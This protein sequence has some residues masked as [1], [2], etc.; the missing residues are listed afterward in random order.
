MDLST[1]QEQQIFDE[2]VGFSAKLRQ[3]DITLYNINPIGVSEPLGLADYY[4]NFLNGV[5]KPYQAQFG[6]LGLQVLAT[7]SG[8]LVFEGN[9]DVVGLIQK[10]L[11]DAQS[12]YQITFDPLPADKPNEYHRIEVHVDQPGLIARTRT[13][14]YANSTAANPSR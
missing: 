10:S 9:S 6:N 8:G 3:I 2:I 4:R 12:W 1:R 14:Y 5:S 11:V 13:G 7:Q